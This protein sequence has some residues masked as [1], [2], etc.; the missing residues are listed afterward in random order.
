[1][2]GV[3]RLGSTDG[4]MGYSTESLLSATLAALKSF[5]GAQALAWCVV[6]VLG[7]AIAL[8]LWNT[9]VLP[10]CL[11]RQTTVPLAKVA[12]GLG[13]IFNGI[14]LMLASGF[15]HDIRLT[16]KLVLKLPLLLQTASTLL[17][18][19]GPIL[20]LEVA[21][22]VRSSGVLLWAV[23]LAVSALVIGANP[24]VNV[25]KFR[26]GTI[27]WSGLLAYGALPLFVVFFQRLARNLERPNLE[28]RARFILKLMALWLAAT[29]TLLASFFQFPPVIWGLM[30]LAGAL[31]LMVCS[32]LLFVQFFRLIR[33]LQAEITR[34]L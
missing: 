9:I 7:A 23:V 17:T 29:G 34:R 18:V 13:L 31:G 2:D 32:V 14:L 12:L 22:R 6:S 10:A 33:G 21:P 1:V 15:I 19:L 3:V 11:L 16:P 5:P 4:A 20:C 27:S 24:E 25:V 8:V 28:A 26:N 30:Y